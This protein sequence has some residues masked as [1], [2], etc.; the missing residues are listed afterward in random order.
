M[1]YIRSRPGFANYLLVQLT[2][3]VGFLLSY[4]PVIGA[5]RESVGN[6]EYYSSAAHIVMFLLWANC[7]ITIRHY[8]KCTY[9]E[10]F[11]EKS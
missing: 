5:V 7:F 8:K 1:V 4:T 3:A 2:V 9:I 11:P 6:S 10:G